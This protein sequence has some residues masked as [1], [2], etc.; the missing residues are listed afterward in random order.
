MVCLNSALLIRTM[1]VRCGT[2]MPQSRRSLAYDNNQHWVLKMQEKSHLMIPMA[3]S[4]THWY[5]VG[6]NISLDMIAGSGYLNEGHVS[7]WI[8]GTY[9]LSQLRKKKNI[10][11][12]KT[13]NPETYGTLFLTTWEKMLPNSSSCLLFSKANLSLHL[14][15]KWRYYSVNRIW[16]QGTEITQFLAN[17][18]LILL[19]NHDYNDFIHKSH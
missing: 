8:S 2:E 4:V 6:L 19:N 3:N 1:V 14:F 12:S 9:G 5:G 17:F 15:S 18:L 7:F 11:I 10:Y 13:R 16:S